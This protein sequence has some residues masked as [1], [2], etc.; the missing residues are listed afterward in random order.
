[1]S[2]G[3]TWHVTTSLVMGYF[4][5]SLHWITFRMFLW[6]NIQNCILYRFLWYLKEIYH[7]V[8]S[9][10]NF[11]FNDDTHNTN[12][13]ASLNPISLYLFLSIWMNLFL[14][15]IIIIRFMFIST[16]M[17]I[18]SKSFNRIKWILFTVSHLNNLRNRLHGS[19]LP[20]VS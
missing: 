1:M 6:L 4:I 17:Q 10:H 11:F 16:N 18:Y 14:H 7:I 8:L 20:I 13:A 5:I 12:F 15:F 2:E 3:E 19:E 9:N